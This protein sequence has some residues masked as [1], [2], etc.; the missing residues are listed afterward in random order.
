MPLRAS[1]CHCHLEAVT[2]PALVIVQVTPAPPSTPS[3]VP[4][5][6]TL[7]VL[8]MVSGLLAPVRARGPLVLECH[9]PL[10]RCQ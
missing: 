5:D 8:V 9:W 7:P 6:V 2:S 1:D 3:F 10:L 4:V